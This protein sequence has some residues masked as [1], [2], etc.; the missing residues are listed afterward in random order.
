MG[1]LKKFYNKNGYFLPINV[2]ENDK[3]NLSAKKLNALHN[4]PPSK[5]KHPWNLQAHLLADW[6]Y[7][8]CVAPK[9]LDAV[10]EVIGCL[11]YTSTLPTK[12]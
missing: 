12:A 6:I 11:L 9:L 7:D 2:L 5:I 8:L 1:K 4:N 3:I 10:E